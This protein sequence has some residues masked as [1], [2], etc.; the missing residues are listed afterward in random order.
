MSFGFSAAT[1]AAISAAT[2]VASAG[3]SA[4]SSYTQAN[5]Q[6]KAL[7]YQ[8]RVD[9]N[10]AKIAEYQRSATLQQG[11]EQA[12]QAMAQRA[13]LIGKQRAALTSNGVDLNSGSAVDLLAST[14]FLG[15]QDVNQIQ[16]N[17]ARKAW[18]YDVEGG[19]ATTQSNLDKWKADS[20]NPITIGGMAG[21]SSLLT[22]A[23]M[24]ASSRAVR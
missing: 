24:F 22:S 8:A 1:W 17:A 15:Q 11:E 20:T 23:S 12:Q 10:N 3:V 13:Q 21:A 6:K 14:E 5:A 18:G 19:N 2:A 16:S 4:Y 9:A 7:N